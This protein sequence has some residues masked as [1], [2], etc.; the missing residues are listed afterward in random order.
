MQNTFLACGHSEIGRKDYCFHLCSVS[1]RRGETIGVP[2]PSYVKLSAED[3]P[4]SDDE[5]VEMDKLPYASAVGSLMYA[6]IATQ[7]D[8]AFPV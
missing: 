2:L 3:S 6:M 7:L 5:M 4:T 8:I 1:I